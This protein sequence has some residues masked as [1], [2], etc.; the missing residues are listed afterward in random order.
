LVQ[1]YKK[2]LQVNKNLKKINLEFNELLGEGAK[3][4]FEGALTS[5]IEDLNIRGNGLSNRGLTLVANV[6]NE[7]GR[8]HDKLKI[9]DLSNNEI[10]E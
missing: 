1:H 4:L 8:M 7:N 2:Y 9:L 3:I 10:T 6:F 5:N